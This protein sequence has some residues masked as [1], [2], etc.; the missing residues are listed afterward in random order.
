MFTPWITIA[1]V[2]F[3]LSLICIAGYAG[4]LIYQSIKAKTIVLSSG[5]FFSSDEGLMRGFG[6]AL[7]PWWEKLLWETLFFAIWFLVILGCWQLAKFC[8][9]PQLRQSIIILMLIGIGAWALLHLLPLT[10]LLDPQGKASM[11]V[12]VIVNVILVIGLGLLLIFQ[13]HSIVGQVQ[14]MLYRQRK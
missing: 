9:K 1:T 11:W 13:H 2:W 3:L 7:S 8:R 10:G 12:A 4:Y 14:N 5:T 6:N